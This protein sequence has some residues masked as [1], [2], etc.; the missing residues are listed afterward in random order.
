[1]YKKLDEYISHLARNKSP[2]TLRNYELHIG[3]FID[4]TTDNN[5][6]VD[7]FELN[8]EVYLDYIDFLKQTYAPKSIHAHMTAI[9]GWLTFL[10]RK[11]YI[12][13]MPFLD[14]GELN[15][16]LP[17]IQRKKAKSLTLEQLRS[18]LLVSR[19]DTLKE[20]IIRTFY[21]TG[22]RVSE[23]VN[24]KLSD[25]EIFPN[26][27]ILKVAGKGKGGMSKVRYVILTKETFEVIKR[28]INERPFKTEYIFASLKTKKPFTERRIDQIIKEVSKAA[29]IDGVTTHIFR[30]SVTT[31][32]LEN[33]MPIEYVSQYLGHANINTTTQNYADLDLVLHKKFEKFHRSL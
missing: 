15:E 13:K 17:V 29:D 16:Y 22:M 10:H 1:M 5:L 9:Y 31:H 12:S 18:M 30:K 25:I 2:Y 7:P 14:S 26:R 20:A 32:L 24:A 8:Q 3:K 6:A 33:E 11:G 23:L 4:W 21:D 28:M 27:I 19:E